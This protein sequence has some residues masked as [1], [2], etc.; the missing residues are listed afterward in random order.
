M[1]IS[2]R[3]REI[4]KQKFDNKCVYCGCEL[5]KGWHVDE[6]YPVRRNYKW[7]KNKTRYIYDG[8]Y[9]NPQNL[10]INNQ[11]PSCPSCNINKHSMNLEDFRKLIEG[12]MRHLNERNTQYKIAKRYGLIQETIKPI[13]F[14]FET[15]TKTKHYDT[16]SNT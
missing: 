14:Y 2:K 7:N 10:H 13:I 4:I 15:L 16:N 8:T 9:M 11:V 6:L 12:F 1:Y 5:Q 3:N